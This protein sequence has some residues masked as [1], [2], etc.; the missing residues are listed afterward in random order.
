MS[1]SSAYEMGVLKISE[2]KKKAADRDLSSSAVNRRHGTIKLEIL[3]SEHF[4]QLE[5]LAISTE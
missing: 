1:A 5:E 4:I 2:G 3:M